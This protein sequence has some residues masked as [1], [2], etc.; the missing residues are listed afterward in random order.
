MQD[1]STARN[2]KVTILN[3]LKMLRTEAD[4]EFSKIF[5]SSEETARLLRKHAQNPEHYYKVVIFLPLL[6]HLISQLETKFCPELY[7]VTSLEQ[8]SVV[9]HTNFKK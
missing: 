1:L 9:H 2:Y 8:C 3:R 6:D 7:K 4:K 5:K